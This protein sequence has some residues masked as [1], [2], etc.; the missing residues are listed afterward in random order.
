MYNTIIVE[1]EGKCNKAI[2]LNSQPLH[3]TEVASPNAK[4]VKISSLQLTVAVWIL[5]YEVISLYTVTCTTFSPA[6]VIA[7]NLAPSTRMVSTRRFLYTLHA[8]DN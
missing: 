6:A 3:I 5:L 4:S 1:A 8:A 7:A 2:T